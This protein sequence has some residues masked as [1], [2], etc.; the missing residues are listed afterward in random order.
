MGVV[1][2]FADLAEAR[3]AFLAAEAADVA[4]WRVVHRA[5]GGRDGYFAHCR[6]R[7]DRGMA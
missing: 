5:H 1:V 4:A 6:A 3:A 7:G 2:R